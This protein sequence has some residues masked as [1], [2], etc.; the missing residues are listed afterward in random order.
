MH[1][2][3]EKVIWW[4]MTLSVKIC[5]MKL[6]EINFI[7]KAHL[8]CWGDGYKYL[9]AT[10]PSYESSHKSYNSL[11]QL[12]P[13]WGHLFLFVL[14]MK[15]CICINTNF[16]ANKSIRFLFLPQN[17][18]KFSLSVVSPLLLQFHVQAHSEVGCHWVPGEFCP[19]KTP[20]LV[21]TVPWR[22]C[23]NLC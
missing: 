20:S 6:C 14:S 3:T 4:I 16:Y 8:F 5:L 15:M 1:I 19:P 2:I 9:S 13:P 11:W 22:S 23:S 18:R 21:H 10:C 17:W 12:V 7:H